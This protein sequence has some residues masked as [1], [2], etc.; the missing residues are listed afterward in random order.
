MGM[1]D[2]VVFRS[3]LPGSPPAFIG[4]AHRFQTKDFDCTLDLYVIE[5]D[6]TLATSPTFTGE[7]EFYTSN[8]VGSGPGVYTR[9]GEDAE[10]VS[11]K[12]TFVDGRLTAIEETERDRKPAL[13]A[14]RQSAYRSP[15]LTK[16]EVKAWRDRCAERLAGHKVFVLWGGR[17][18]DDG[19]WATVVHDGRTE[20]CVEHDGELELLDR[21][22]RDN[23]FFDSKESAATDRVK[24]KDQWG[25][26]KRE[27]DELVASRS[28][29]SSPVEK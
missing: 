7:V 3:T 5:S 20:L 28:Q 8:I 26:A 27:Y 1:F 12:A 25:S 23:I 6:G 13:H 16:A 19:Y 10:S 24:S 4:P 22:Q 2:E 11:Y 15:P 18:V 14:T 21:R 29:P 9:D 17:E